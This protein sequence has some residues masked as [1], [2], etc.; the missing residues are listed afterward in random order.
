MFCEHCGNSGY[1]CV[2]GYDQA[3]PTNQRILA[4]RARAH[5]RDIAATRERLAKLLA[6][7]P[8]VLV[9]AG[10]RPGD[11]SDQGELFSVEPE[12]LF[13]DDAE[14]RK[15]LEWEDSHRR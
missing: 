1:C 9:A 13:S 7:L 14:F 6:D 12:N 4:L 11:S 10:R 3:N 15:E 8:A 5:E 2:C